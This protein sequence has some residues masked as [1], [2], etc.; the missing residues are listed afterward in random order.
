MAKASPIEFY[1]NVKAEAKK[2]TWPGKKEL[3]VST[4][5]VFTMVVIA[6][7]FMFVA[8]QI[9]AALVEAILNLGM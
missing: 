4:I 1:R 2:V 8:D 9:M 3:T 5:A 6:S 7:I